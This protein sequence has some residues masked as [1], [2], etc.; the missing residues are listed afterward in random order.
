MGTSHSSCAQRRWIFCL[1]WRP[2][3]A[4]LQR[5]SAPLPCTIPRLPVSV[6]VS[7]A[8]PS[9]TV[10]VTLLVGTS[11]RTPGHLAARTRGDPPPQPDRRFTKDAEHVS[12]HRFPVCQD[13]GACAV[14]RCRITR[15]RL[16]S[17][18]TRPSEFFRQ[19]SS[20]FTVQFHWPAW[21]EN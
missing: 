12:E 13:V 14:L 8:L 4:G 6:V 17:V 5:L 16:L 1:P 11:L 10:Y 21:T 9:S 19:G 15:G 7:T 18:A 3:F 20:Q 2:A